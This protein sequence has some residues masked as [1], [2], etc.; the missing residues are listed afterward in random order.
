MATRSPRR[1]LPAAHP[2][3]RSG[4]LV[5]AGLL[6]L[7]TLG[8]CATGA[9]ATRPE[10]ARVFPD[11]HARILPVYLAK[12][13]ESQGTRISWNDMLE[14]AA[15][16]DVVIIGEN[17]G[18][19]VG[20]PWAA[21]LFDDLLKREPKTGLALEFFE[22]DEQSRLDDYL[23]GLSEEKVFLQRTGRGGG[24]GGN[25]PPGHRRM[26]EAAKAASR[27]VIAANTPRAIIRYLRGK[28]Y[29]ELTALTP[30]QQ[31]LFQVPL[32][33]AEGRYRADFDAV[34]T[35]MREATTHGAKPAESA[36]AAKTE[37]AAS[38][39]QTAEPKAEFDGRFRAHQLWDWTMADSVVKA[40][41]ASKPVV[42]VVGRFHSDFFGGTAQ[43][44]TKLKPG[45]NVVIISVVDR[46]AD[47]LQSE[48]HDRADFVVYVGPGP[49]EEP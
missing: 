20:L 6:A 12:G 21:T 34:M 39:P 13:G 5:A 18:H 42:L 24:S 49:S 33:Q 26:V 4:L 29:E 15:A 47:A 23:L 7:S 31:R 36:A 8:G 38:K 2:V 43:A 40:T 14:R 32:A 10:E 19:P 27:P 45:T 11:A 17:H 16:A 48:D 41:A 9:A 46:A 22:R 30:E 3:L 25:Y 37:A 1:R 35:A 28:T 44:I